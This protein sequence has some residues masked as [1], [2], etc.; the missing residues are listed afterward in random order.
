MTA[1]SPQSSDDPAACPPAGSPAAPAETLSW[2]PS[3]ASRRYRI[4]VLGAGRVGAVLGAA[5]RFAGHPVVAAAGTSAATRMRLETLL[6]DL[7]PL[8]ATDVARAA[9]LLLLTVPD[10]ALEDLVER[11]AAEGAV[12]ADQVVVHTSGRHGTGVLAAAAELGAVPVALHPAMTFTGTDLD[13][14]RLPG[15]VLGLTAGPRGRAVGE[16]L[17]ADLGAQVMNVPE[18]QR[19][20]Y[21]AAL[22]HGAN[23]L[24]TLVVQAMELLRTT[25]SPDPAAV[26]RPLLQAALDNGLAYGDAALTG[27]VVRGDARTVAAHLAA[28]QDADSGTAAAYRAMAAATAR[29]AER[30]GRLDADQA[31]VIEGL[32]GSDRE[33]A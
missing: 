23:H 4:G 3:G 30:D 26:L 1:A 2:R 8:P 28:L 5:L 24:A 7:S 31:A 21:H 6:P 14:A 29:R 25:G 15:C 19:S 17:A 11:L 9:D 13:L 33:P 18:E 10:D 20:R 22:V 12:R 32:L 27:P 16:Q